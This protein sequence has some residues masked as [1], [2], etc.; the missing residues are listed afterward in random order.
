M[1]LDGGL[2]FHAT[3]Y[4]APTSGRYEGASHLRLKSDDS[5]PKTLVITSTATS[6]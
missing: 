5:V 4:I 1:I 2:L 3:L 6:R